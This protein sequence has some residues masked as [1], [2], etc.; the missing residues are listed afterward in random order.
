MPAS[1][2]VAVLSAMEAVSAREW[3]ALVDAD[4]PFYVMH[5]TC[6]GGQRFGLSGNR[7]AALPFNGVAGRAAGRC[8]AAL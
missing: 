3:D 7:L 6:A 5:F 2:S 4:Q 8:H 1:L